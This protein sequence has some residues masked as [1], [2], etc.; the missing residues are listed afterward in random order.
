[1]A[2]ETERPNIGEV[3]LAPAF[4]NGH[5]VIRV[6]ETP[7]V[8]RPQSPV[9]QQPRANASPAALQL[10]PRGNRIDAAV[11]AY[12]AVSLESLLTKITGIRAK[13]PLSYAP[14]GTERVPPLRYFEAA[15]PAQRTPVGALRQVFEASVSARHGSLTGALIEHTI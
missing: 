3:A 15:P 10:T 7:A 9:R 11:G 14:V 5:N 2:A 8:Q 1:M 4:G 6:P 13:S 12:A